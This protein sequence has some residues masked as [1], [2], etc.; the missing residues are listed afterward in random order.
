[1]VDQITQNN[2]LSINIQSYFDLLNKK[3]KKVY[4]LANKARKLGLD[5]SHE[6]EIPIAKDIADR[7]EGLIGPPGVGKKIRE[8]EKQNLSREKVAFKI[9]G[10][11]CNG[12]WYG[13]AG[14]DWK[15]V[16]E[17]EIAAVS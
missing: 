3:L 2:N 9:A 11:I 14:M 13:E 10:D 17:E 5:P 1:M 16:S 7:V 12:Y 4:N 15:A 6:V 8:Y